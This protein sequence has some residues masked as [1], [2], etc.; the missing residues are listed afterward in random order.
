MRKFVA[1]V[2]IVAFSAMLAFASAAQAQTKTITLVLGRMGPGECA[3]RAVE[4][5]HRQDAA[6]R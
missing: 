2:G 5:L 4:G 6:S 1:G 3:R